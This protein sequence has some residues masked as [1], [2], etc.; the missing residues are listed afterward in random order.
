MGDRPNERRSYTSDRGMTT[1][2]RLNIEQQDT[3]LTVTLNDPDRFNRIDE[4]LHAELHA[5]FEDLAAADARA[6]VFASTGPHFSV[7]G[8]FDFILH[9]NAECDRS[10]TVEG[11]LTMLSSFLA[12]PFPVVVALQGDV[13]GLATSLVLCSDAVVSHPGASMSDPHVAVGLVAGDGGCLA[14]PQSAG[15]LV[16]K[17]YLLSGDPMPCSVAHQAG[18]VTDLVDTAVEVLPRAMEIAERMA[19]RPPVGVQGTK[20]ALNTLVRHR[21]DE[22]MKVSA[23]LEVDSLGTAD[24]REAISAF[25]ERREPVFGG[26]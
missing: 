15:I 24:V 21:F 3:V 5:A 2:S 16:A 6:L 20:R 25:R 22:V 12:I 14:W 10:E 19:A 18:L 9:Q 8:D 11:A 23:H 13:M 4:E 7:G 17:R 1:S 26:S